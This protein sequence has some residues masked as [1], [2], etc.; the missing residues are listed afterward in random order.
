MD[1][2]FGG[3]ETKFTAINPADL[4]TSKSY[5]TSAG[6]FLWGA[7]DT[8]TKTGQQQ[9]FTAAQKAGMTVQQWEVPLTGH[10]WDTATGAL[11]HTLPWIATQT[12][13]TS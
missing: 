7:T 13:L 1:T 8:D 11:T 3:D 5:P 12:N 2:A 4:L 9:L 10:D 6:W